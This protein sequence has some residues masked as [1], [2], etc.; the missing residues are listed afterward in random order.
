MRKHVSKRSPLFKVNPIAEE[1]VIKVGG[2][3]H[4]APLDNSEKNPLILPN[5]SHIS[6]LEKKSHLSILLNHWTCFVPRLIMVVERLALTLN[7]SIKINIMENLIRI[8][9]IVRV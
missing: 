5:K 8:S 6:T 3:L 9:Y 1:R 7:Y 2:R 4:H